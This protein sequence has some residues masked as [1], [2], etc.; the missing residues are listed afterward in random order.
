[1]KDSKLLDL[2]RR[3]NSKERRR[4]REYLHSPFHNKNQ[5][6]RQLSDYLYR[7]QPHFQHDELA[8]PRVFAHLF[9]D[10]ATYRDLRINNLQSDLLQLLYAF[11][12]QQ[13][14]EQRRDLH[15][16][17]LLDELFRKDAERHLERQLR[18]WKTQQNQSIYRSYDYHLEQYY[19]NEKEDYHRLRKA[20]RSHTEHLQGQ[21]D[22]LDR[23]YLIQKL[24]LACEMTSRNLVA[25]AGYRCHHLADCLR[26]YEETEELQSEPALRLYHQ[27]LQMLEQREARHW[28]PRVRQ[29]LREE[30]Q[31]I[32][33]EECWPLY[34][35]ALNHCIIRINSGES[36]YYRQILELYQEL[37]DRQIIFVNGYLT[38]WSYKNIITTG[39]RLQEFEWTADFI[40]RYEDRLLPEERANAK[41]YNLAALCQARGDYTQALQ[42]LHNVEFTD[43]SYHLGAKTIQLKSYYA[44]GESEALLA[45]IE[46]FRKYLGRN[47][48][49]AIYRQ[50]AN[51]NM[52]QLLRK[53]QQLQLRAPRLERADFRRRHRHLSQSLDGAQPVANKDWLEEILGEVTQDGPH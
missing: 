11:L 7:F 22:A 2:L 1:M 44:L 42:L 53:I 49:I 23:F 30:S 13:R 41:L 17:F 43:T 39:I 35:F 26:W 40:H 31:C 50:A 12:G 51:H 10:K 28:F 37:L 33:R 32:P 8:K 38:Q 14:Y 3:L 52:L 24:R 9:G 29:L 16:Q 18:N 6:L 20:I 46:A 15:K 4:F 27:V 21:N 48:Q 45:L 5:K 34:S 36:D 47:R 19:R 25:Q